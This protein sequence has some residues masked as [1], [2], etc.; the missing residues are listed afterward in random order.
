MSES[1]LTRRGFTKLLAASGAAAAMGTTMA[2]SFSYAAHAFGDEGENTNKIYQAT[3]HGCI[4]TCGVRVYTEN[5]VAVKIEGHPKSPTSMGSVCLKCMNQ[6]HTCY[7]PRRVLYPI[8]RVGQRGAENAQWERISWDEALEL[9]GTKIAEAI[10]KYGTYSFFTSCGGGGN[11]SITHASATAIT[12]GSPTFFEPGC[13][14][15]WLPRVNIATAMH[16]HTDNSVADCSVLEPFKGLAKVNALNRG[17]DVDPAIDIDND[18]E[19]IVMW[20][21]QPSV[22]QTAQSGRGVAELRALGVKSVVI[23]PNLTADA[24]KATVWLRI[25]PGSDTAMVL[26]WIRYVLD[27]KLYD[28]EF[29]KYWTNVPFLI[30]PETKLPW[31]AS[32]VWPDYESPTPANTPVYVCVDETTGELSPLPF[33]YPDDIKKQVNPQVLATAEVNGL[34]S[35]SAGQIYWDTADPFTLEKVEEICWVPA[36]LIE[37]AIHIYTDANVA[38]IVCGVATDQQAISSQVPVGQMGLDMMMGYINKPGAALTKTYFGQGANELNPPLAP[39]EKPSRPTLFINGLYGMFSG[40]YGVGYEIGATEEENAARI[41]AMPPGDFPGSQGM[42]YIM[43]QLCLDKLGNRNHKGLSHWEAAHI[44]SVLEA[45]KTGVPYK[46]RVWFDMSGNKL[47]ALGNAGSWYE[48]FDEIDYCICMYPHLTSFQMELADLVLPVEEWLE[49]A[50]SSPMPQ[51]N[52]NFG[53]FPIVHLG[54]T[55]TSNVCMVKVVNA[56]SKKLNE[57][58]ESGSDIMLGAVGATTNVAAPLEPST[59]TTSSNNEMQT[60]VGSSYVHDCDQSKFNL[61][62]PLGTGVFCGCEEE[63]IHLAS[64]AERWGAPS[65]EELHAHPEQY[66]HPEVLVDPDVLFTYDNHLVEADDGLPAGFATESRKCEVYVTMFIKMANTG[67]PFAYPRPQVAVD[68]SIG[69]EITEINPDYEYQGMYSPICQYVEPKESA[70]EGT[71]NYDPEYPYVLT[72]GRVPYFHHGTMRHAPFARELY[73]APDVKMHPNTA[74]KHG[75]E[76]MDWVRISS[77]RGS[78]QGRVYLNPALDER[79]IWMERFWNPECFDSSQKE[80]NGGWRQTNV[81]VLTKNTPP[82]NEVYGSYTNRAFTVKIEKG[83]RPAGIWV[84]PKEFEPFMPTN[85]SE[86]YPEIGRVIDLPQTPRMTFDDWSAEP[87]EGEE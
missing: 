13:A 77:R 66:L 43:N 14:Q 22:S 85:A 9:A 83:E 55:V 37:K 38:G 17:W 24:A 19:A 33:G 41:A 47:A 56:A 25:R 27:N 12:L 64:L 81:N 5:D 35:R 84:E 34:S 15:C 51:L 75:L 44:P 3:C 53:Y 72:S 80:K 45:I 1:T 23:D 74:K 48:A 65:F 50:D 49:Y 57:M 16:G 60:S 7:S 61:H 54:E 6:L 26:G 79:V 86:L 63:S 8:K 52:Y 32:E 68:S 42:L 82:Y 18:M 69:E 87:A 59:C 39:G 62:F 21:T 2:G 40:Q 73:P 11:Y 78:V 76:H 10:E 58:I 71:P 30:N 31:L 70:Y 29:T 67:W 36:D 28:E 4:Q 20:A 46:P